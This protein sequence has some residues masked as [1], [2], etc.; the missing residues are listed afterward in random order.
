MSSLLDDAKIKSNQLLTNPELESPNRLV[1]VMPKLEKEMRIS[2]T[3]KI[4]F[5]GSI[6]RPVSNLTALLVDYG[7]EK[8]EIVTRGWM[9]PQNLNGKEESTPIIPG[10][11]YTFT[12]DMQP[13]D[14]VFQAGGQIGVVLI[15]SDYDYTIRPK[16]GTKLTVKLSEL[17]L[18]IVK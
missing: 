17:T 8:P 10:K 2:G 3:P 11:D 9:D 13:D 18:P 5:K 14:Y 7:G 1:Y 16:A 12:W 4:S 15:A 6:D